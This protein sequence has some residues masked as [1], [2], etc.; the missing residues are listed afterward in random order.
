MYAWCMCVCMYVC[1]HD[2]CMYV[3]MCVCMYVSIYLHISVCMCLCAYVC[4][5]LLSQY[6]ISYQ[7]AL[8]GD[9]QH[10]DLRERI[11]FQAFACDDDDIWMRRKRKSI[12][13]CM[14]SNCASAGIIICVRLSVP[15][16]IWRTTPF[17]TD[18]RWTI[19]LLYISEYPFYLPPPPPPIALLISSPIYSSLLYKSLFFSSP[20][21]YSSLYSSHFSPPF[22][23][24]PFYLPQTTLD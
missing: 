4:I 21:F 17:E 18:T 12:L 6:A 16:L 1:M 10:E 5:Y 20:F 23:T 9:C 2:V 15:I 8:L 11:H 22:S 3:C 7:M 24:L 14:N 13:A 19:W